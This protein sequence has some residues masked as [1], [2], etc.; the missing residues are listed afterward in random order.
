MRRQEEGRRQTG[1]QL[2]QRAEEYRTGGEENGS[3]PRSCATFMKS[4]AKPCAQA[5][6]LV[7]T[8]S[9]VQAETERLLRTSTSL[10]DK[11]KAQ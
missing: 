10:T 7:A 4:S 8:A 5:Q 3:R 6:E 1:E 2:R 9:D 11:P